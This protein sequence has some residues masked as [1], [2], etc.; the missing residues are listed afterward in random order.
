MVAI[1]VGMQDPG[2][3]E[4]TNLCTVMEGQKEYQHVAW[5]PGG[6]EGVGGVQVASQDLKYEVLGVGGWRKFI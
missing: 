1:W 3:G 6:H 5:Q 2:P 4:R